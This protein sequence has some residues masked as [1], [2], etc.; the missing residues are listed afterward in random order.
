MLT[1]FLALTLTQYRIP[2]ID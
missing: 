2:W 1:V